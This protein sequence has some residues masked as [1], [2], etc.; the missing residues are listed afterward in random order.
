MPAA[1]RGRSSNQRSQR[2]MSSA[3]DV[4]PQKLVVRNLRVYYGAKKALGPVSMDI[5]KN[6]SPR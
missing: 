6:G 1:A 3:I 4:A 2:L 5:P